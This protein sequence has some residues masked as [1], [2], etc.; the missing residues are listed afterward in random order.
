MICRLV[1]ES[2][3]WLM[4]Q[5]RFEEAEGVL[6]KIASN[7]KVNLGEKPLNVENAVLPESGGRLWHLFTHKKLLLRTLIIFF[8]W[9]GTFWGNM[10][11]EGLYDPSK[12]AVGLTG[13]KCSLKCKHSSD[14]LNKLETEIRTPALYTCVFFCHLS[15]TVSS[16]FLWITE[17]IFP[18]R[19]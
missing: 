7:N 13:V 12:S 4:S 8:N 2:P 14:R 3:R 10:G 17:I 15:P 11:W 19:L 18:W 16:Y 1:P 6:R 9:W 5:G